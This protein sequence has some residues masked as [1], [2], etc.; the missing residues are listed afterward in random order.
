MATLED[1]IN[2]VNE[3]ETS[4]T[5]LQDGVDTLTET[6]NIRKNNLDQAISEAEQFAQ[7][8]EDYKNETN[9]IKT[10]ILAERRNDYVDNVLYLGKAPELT[11]D[12]EPFWKIR[13]IE[14][15]I[16][17]TTTVSVANNVAWTDRLTIEYN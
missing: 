9:D 13:K 16:D 4:V 8:A 7:Q 12:S 2:S 15:F 14:V 5:N 10:K 1:L 6:V 3:L 11:L 17:G